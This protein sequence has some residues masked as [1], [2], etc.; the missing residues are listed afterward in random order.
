MPNLDTIII[1]TAAAFAITV[2]PGPSMLYVMSISLGQGRKAGIFSALGLATGLLIHTIAASLGL[3]VVFVYSPFAYMIIKYLGALYLIYIGIRMLINGG[4]LFYSTETTPKT[5]SS[6]IYGQ[7]ILT[8]LLNPKTALFF[9]SFLPQFVDPTLGPPALQM[10]IFGS[11]LILT[12]FSADL[13]IA[14]TGGT[15]S[16]WLARRPLIQKM[17]RWLAGTVLISLGMRLAISERK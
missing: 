11:I 15:I 7:G 13:F 16:Q 9:L 17:Q 10:S 2:C 12:A 5:Q 6:R 4:A 1:F 14:I 8:E 3:S